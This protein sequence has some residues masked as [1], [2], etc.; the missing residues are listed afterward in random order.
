V[1]KN[2]A[3][4]L[5]RRRWQRGETITFGALHVELLSKLVRDTVSQLGEPQKGKARFACGPWGRKPR[6][7][8]LTGHGGAHVS[9]SGH[10]TSIGS[11]QR[12]PKTREL[13]VRGGEI[14]VFFD[15]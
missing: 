12:S 14:L 15:A 8:F 2:F 13:F 1:R 6:H 7:V 11:T 3:A 10:V 5:N 4:P 9:G